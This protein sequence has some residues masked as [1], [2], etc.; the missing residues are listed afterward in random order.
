MGDGSDIMTSTACTGKVCS[1][2]P[3]RWLVNLFPSA[4]SGNVH[5]MHISPGGV[6]WEP[7]YLHP[8]RSEGDAEGAAE[9]CRKLDVIAA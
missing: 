9:N 5:L 1:I 2:E 3:D 7:V 8:R 6:G 4:G